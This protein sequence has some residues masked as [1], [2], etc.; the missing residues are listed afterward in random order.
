MMSEKA[1]SFEFTVPVIIIGAGGCGLTA[2][3]A[4]KERGVDLLVIERDSSP[5][6]STAMS[7]GLIPAAGTSEQSEKGIEDNPQ[8]FARDIL[9]K[10]N[11]KT[12][13]AIVKSL[14]KNSSETIRWL[15]DEHNIPLE[16]V[17]G[18]LYP[19]HSRQRM[20]GTPNR[21]GAEL[22]GALLGATAKLGIDI[23]T[24]ACVSKLYK[25]N[26]NKITG[27]GMTRPDGK[28]EKI[29]CQALIL[30]C[31]G[32]AGNAQ[33]VADYIPEIA[34][35]TFYGHGGN[36][37]D[38][39]RWGRDM[40]AKTADMA[41]YQGHGGLATNY[42]IPIL[43][44]II[45]QGGFQV[46][47]KG[48]RFSDETQGYS[49]QAAKV[50]AEPKQAAWM[51]FDQKIHNYMM[52]FDDYKD[53]FSA[54]AILKAHTIEAVA[55]MAKLPPMAFTGTLKQI[56]EHA[57]GKEPDPFG[58]KFN[59]RDLLT[60]SYYFVKVTGALFHT[61]GGLVVDEKARVMGKG[62]TPLPNLFAGGGAARGISGPGCSG[63]M[64]GNGLLTATTYGRL[65]GE[66][67]ATLILQ[68]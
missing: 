9:E 59:P 66:A 1:E 12:D 40:G 54:G 2:A 29:G 57:E 7:T 64:A 31:S 50:N 4:V 24:N 34:G 27:I 23:L 37:G 68:N 28:L 19:G 47:L 48:L 36:K 25:N 65:A 17:D 42:G 61:Q 11:G 6:G 22:M 52:A 3:L 53:A 14:A 45:M 63:Y 49:E 56:S 30:A 67:A 15:K 33:M 55:K 20:Y 16:L 60:P 43:W 38:A 13:S 58:R 44:P 62:D 32:F 41:S 35:A 39:I 46:N 26:K 21:S 51:I 10:T 8:I 18:F 5:S